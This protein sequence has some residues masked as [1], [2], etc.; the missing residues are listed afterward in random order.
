MNADRPKGSR[1]F[2]TPSV[3]QSVVSHE[4]ICEE[5]GSCKRSVESRERER[6]RGNGPGTVQATRASNTDKRTVKLIRRVVLWY[7]LPSKAGR[8]KREYIEVSC[9]Y[10]SFERE[11]IERESRG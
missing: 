10:E 7:V 9:T 8:E 1:N 4:A 2:D 6:V 3:P 5:L 11:W